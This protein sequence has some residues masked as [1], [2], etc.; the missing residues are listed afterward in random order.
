MKSNI[1]QHFSSI[2]LTLMVAL[3]TGTAQ[4]KPAETTSTDTFEL[5]NQSYIAGE[6]SIALDH[7][8][9]AGRQ[10]GFSASLLYNMGNTYAAMG[11]PGEAILS[12]KQALRIDP[13]NDGI[14]SSLTNL[15][16]NQGLYREDQPIW[17][18]IPNLLDG[19][20]WML[21]SGCSF[22]LFSCGLLFMAFKTEKEGK[23]IPGIAATAA[24][25]TF[26]TTLPFAFYQYQGWNDAV[27]L[28]ESR[29]QISPFADAA[30]IGTIKEGRVVRPGKTHNEYVLVTDP[31]GRKGW[32]SKD[33]LGKI[34]ELPGSTS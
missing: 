3:I 26:L 4:A 24:L 19:D 2:V 28:T 5:G 29:L 20:Q 33:T 34:S 32:L 16:K 13:G 17:Q 8:Q 27:V 10:K 7:Y 1:T 12:Y 30:S 15:R 23:R 6:F 25:I 22:F 31:S 18:Q 14:Q 21:I 9:A 11:Q